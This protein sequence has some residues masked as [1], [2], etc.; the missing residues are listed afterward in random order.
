[1]KAVLFDQPGGPEHLYVGDAPRPEPAADEL[2]VGVEATALNRADLLQREGAYPPPNGASDILGLEVAGTVA[3]VGS[4]CKGWTVGDRI[5]AL[6][7]GGGYAEYAVVPQQMAMRIPGTLSFEEAAAIPEVF[8]TAFQALF[9]LGDLK[10]NE[11]V[12]IHAGASGV[13]TA[14]IQLARAVGA[15]PYVTASAPKHEACLALGAEAAIDYKT[16]DFA[17]RIAKLTD[18]KGAD[19]ILDFIGASYFDANIQA[20]ARDGRLVILALMGGRTV[21]S[22]DLR[23][24]FAKRAHI[25]FTTLRSRSLSYKIDLTQDFAR[26]MLPLFDEGKLQPVIDSVMAWQDVQKAHRRM[27]ANENIGKIVL[28]VN[29]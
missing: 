17:H 26:R 29:E 23:S 20:L 5:C 6:L 9:W 21:D 22:V 1:M 8:L 10:G 18:G 11:R 2:L 14:A 19:V 3:E 7:P 15:T 16:E 4:S 24:L 12:L 27:G 13:G 28:R 25:L